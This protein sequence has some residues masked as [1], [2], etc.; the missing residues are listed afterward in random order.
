MCEVVLI[1]SNFVLGLR[2]VNTK[3]K[4]RRDKDMK[5]SETEDSTDDVF[6]S[7]SS[8]ISVTASDQTRTP[9]P[10]SPTSSTVS[11]STEK[12]SKGLSRL[13]AF[14]PRKLIPKRFKTAPEVSPLPLTPSDTDTSVVVEKKETKSKIPKRTRIMRR[15]TF[16]KDQKVSPNVEEDTSSSSTTPMSLKRE[17][18]E[19]ATLSISEGS[20]CPVEERSVEESS[21]ENNSERK[22]SSASNQS[23]KQELKITISGK[24][25]EKLKK[26]YEKT[27]DDDD[28][29]TQ[30]F[31]G[32]K[33][34]V[35]AITRDIN[36]ASS[37]QSS[38]SPSNKTSF[39][40][41]SVM[42]KNEKKDIVAL[43]PSPPPTPLMSFH[44]PLKPDTPKPISTISSTMEK[45]QVPVATTPV[46]N[47]EN[48]KLQTDRDE[49][50]S[51]QELPDIRK[52]LKDKETLKSKLIN[53]LNIS[54]SVHDIT[55]TVIAPVAPYK[56][57]EEEI[58]SIIKDEP[59]NKPLTPDEYDKLIK[60]DRDESLTS[61]S[62]EKI[63]TLTTTQENPMKRSETEGN[64]VKKRSKKS[65]GGEES[66]DSGLS[67]SVHVQEP[68]LSYQKKL[69][70]TKTSNDLN[71]SNDNDQES[72]ESVT[73]NKSGEISFRIGTPVRPLQ[74]TQLPG[75]GVT[76][77]TE[78]IS[79][80]SAD[81]NKSLE[82]ISSISS[83]SQSPPL[84]E[85]SRKK[86]KYLPQPTLYS[87]EE[88]ALLEGNFGPPSSF[89]SEYSIDYS[90]NPLSMA[91]TGE[92]TQTGGVVR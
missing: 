22:S 13:K 21:A 6:Y 64:K 15:L 90:L 85:N 34:D 23:S 24:K 53:K 36:K 16:K 37:L 5:K 27:K 48:N 39:M 10:S 7:L 35:S 57:T 87:S 91:E 63:F 89:I 78:S 59:L 3:R 1:I 17:T 61:Q 69:S 82:E 46:S 65:T 32:M 30:A 52:K 86:I 33:Y 50:S 42:K 28:K 49:H 29:T 81:N 8:A 70:P 41:A 84:S 43:L 40:N 67:T 38:S 88:Q 47:N 80:D 72:G 54:R 14:R 58:S 12:K 92:T 4:I 79:I 60:K 11:T 19:G 71:T 66:T 74:A 68:Q 9:S 62:S 45:D 75:G 2:S 55:P 56:I 31:E 18:P 76:H 51:R 83:E 44:I 77:I 25:I 20:L 73:I 26:L